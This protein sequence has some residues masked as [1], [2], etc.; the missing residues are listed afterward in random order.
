MIIRLVKD[1]I[2]NAKYTDIVIMHRIDLL[3]A[4]IQNLIQSYDTSND[5][6]LVCL[7]NK[8][9]DQKITEVDSKIFRFKVLDTTFN[10]NEMST[11]EK[12]FLVAYLAE[13]TRK[14]VWFLD[15]ILNL[16]EDTFNMFISTFGFGKFVNIL[17]RVELYKKS[18]EERLS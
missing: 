4:D 8:I 6:E 7:L 1:G 17:T 13:K 2:G 9:N 3:A 12:V 14:T 18:L 16:E 10:L 15:S 11:A 5:N